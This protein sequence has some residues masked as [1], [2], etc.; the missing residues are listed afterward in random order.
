MTFTQCNY[1]HFVI[2]L[3]PL[4]WTFWVYV[5][6][7]RASS[8]PRSILPQILDHAH[9]G[10]DGLCCGVPGVDDT[11]CLSKL[12]LKLP[13]PFLVRSSQAS[14]L[15]FSGPFCEGFSSGCQVLNNAVP[16]PKALVAGLAVGEGA[17]ETAG[18]LV[19]AHPRYSLLAHAVACHPVTLRR[20][21]ATGVTVTSCGVEG[22]YRSRMRTGQ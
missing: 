16:I 10:G 9:Q 8:H 17:R 4:G 18:T 11:P 14:R 3:F 22:N 6:S 7:R 20:L 21:N 15:D 13:E 1:L 5:F 12:L 19:T 2:C